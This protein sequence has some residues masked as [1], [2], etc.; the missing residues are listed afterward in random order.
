MQEL[1]IGDTKVAVAQDTPYDVLGR[2]T[3]YSV[4]KMRILHEE[5]DRIL[6]KEGV[7]TSLRPRKTRDVDAFKSAVR[8]VEGKD[9]IVENETSVDPT[10][11]RPKVDPRSMLVVSRVH[12][13]INDSLPVRVKATFKDETKSIDFFGG[14]QAV[15]QRI[16]NEYA[17]LRVTYRDDDI[18]TMASRAIHSAFAVNVK[19][20]G[21]VYF[22]PEVFAP[23]VESVARVI[24]QL[25]GCEMVSLPVI[26]REPER[27]TVLK[28]Y[29]KATLERIGELMNMVKETVDKGE[30]IVP[31]VYG[32]F[33][34]EVSYLTEQ[35]TKYE[36]FLNTAIGK[37]EIEMEVLNS[38]LGK[39][40]SMIKED[41][42]A[43]SG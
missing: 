2:I 10:T 30:P 11:L 5:L 38:N 41:K 42:P 40:A 22:I 3:W 9:Y 15:H 12:D 33:A 14:D 34:D 39:L 17:D 20:S 28:Q 7:P 18:R 8:S 27:K 13:H 43:T 16:E 23:S 4:R 32:R 25:P 36:A 26:D 35:R 19:Q 21:G 1:T 6:E 29:E 37:V 24:D 31:S